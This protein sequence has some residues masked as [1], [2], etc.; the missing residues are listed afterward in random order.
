LQYVLIW[1]FSS[2]IFYL[3]KELHLCSIPC[4]SLW[5]SPLANISDKSR[6]CIKWQAQTATILPLRCHQISSC[7]SAYLSFLEGGMV[8]H[9]FPRM[10][11][12]THNGIL[13]F[14]LLS[15]C[16]HFDTNSSMFRS[17]A[18]IHTSMSCIVTNLFHEQ[19]LCVS[20]PILSFKKWSRLM[21]SHVVSVTPPFDFCITQP[22][23]M[24]PGMLHQPISKVH[25]LHPSHHSA[26][27]HRIR[28]THYWHAMAW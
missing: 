7:L 19:V 9:K 6:N 17:C 18:T 23:F 5:S 3:C 26:C 1:Y 16:T 24:K 15:R 21:Q 28:T 20:S 22:V 8:S 12:D 4:S 10:D 25:I 2:C 13:L 11:P 14:L 27:V